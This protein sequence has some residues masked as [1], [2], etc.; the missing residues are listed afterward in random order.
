MSRGGCGRQLTCEIVLDS[1]AGAHCR[2]DESRSLRWELID[3]APAGA[4]CCTAAAPVGSPRRA[5][6]SRGRVGMGKIGVVEEE[7]LGAGRSDGGRRG[8]AGWGLGMPSCRRRG[9]GSVECEM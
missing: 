6:W 3:L 8:L 5:E 9:V 7:R 1:G 4:R 2:Q